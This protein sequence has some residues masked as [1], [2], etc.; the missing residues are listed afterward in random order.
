MYVPILR[1]E[2]NNPYESIF[3]PLPLF[4]TLIYSLPSQ[5][6]HFSGP[7]LVKLM[8]PMLMDTIFGKPIFFVIKVCTNRYRTHL[9][10]SFTIYWVLSATIL[11]ME[12][13]SHHFLERESTHLNWNNH[14]VCGKQNRD[15]LYLSLIH[16]WRCR[17]ST[18]CRSRW[19]PYH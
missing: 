4:F 3:S 2:K 14:C 5:N 15:T 11:L 7:F 9:F 12:C 18:L 8:E 1:R 13:L 16:I 17:R 6:V 19:S 10:S